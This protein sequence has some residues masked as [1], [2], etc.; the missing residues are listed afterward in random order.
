MKGVVNSGGAGLG[1]AIVKGVLDR[2]EAILEIRST[3]GQGS[4]FTV[5]FPPERIAPVRPGHALHF[6]G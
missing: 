2:H 3:P 5:R 1:L 6:Q 4:A